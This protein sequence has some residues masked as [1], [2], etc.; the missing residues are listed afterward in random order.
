MNRSSYKIRID[1]IDLRT[2]ASAFAC[3]LILVFFSYHVYTRTLSIMKI[4]PFLFLLFN[5]Y[6]LGAYSTKQQFYLKNRF[7]ILLM[8]IVVYHVL[9]RLKQTIYKHFFLLYFS[10]CVTLFDSTNVFKY[11]TRNTEKMDIYIIQKRPI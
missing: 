2:S 1:L 9:N 6:I 3:P 11:K 5:N 8:R 4:A 10:F 7:I